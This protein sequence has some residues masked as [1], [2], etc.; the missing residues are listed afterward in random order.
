M[1]QSLRYRIPDTGKPL[2]DQLKSILRETYS[3]DTQECSVLGQDDIGY[4][5]GLRDGGV[6]DADVLIKALGT[7][8]TIEIFLG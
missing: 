1:S 6:K 5:Q 4:L 7:N 8:R 3:L 2:S